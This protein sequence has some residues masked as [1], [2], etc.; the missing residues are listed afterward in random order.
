MQ[1][2]IIAHIHFFTILLPHMNSL[3]ST[4]WPGVL[5]T[6]YNDVNADANNDAGANANSHCKNTAKLQ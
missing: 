5:Y 6:G 2:Q 3:V 1:T 4:I